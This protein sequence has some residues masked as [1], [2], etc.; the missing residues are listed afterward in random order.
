[1]LDWSIDHDICPL[2]DEHGCKIYPHRPLVCQK[3]PERYELP[4]DKT[5]KKTELSY[6]AAFALAK[7]SL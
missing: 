2:Y 6:E 7:K 4:F 3:F 1:M 5:M